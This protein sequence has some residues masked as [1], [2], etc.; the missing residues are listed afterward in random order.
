MH[1]LLA[2]YRAAHASELDA[3]DAEAERLA[4]RLDQGRLAA[5]RTWPFPLHEPERLRELRDE[6]DRRFGPSGATP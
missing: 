3:L 4:A 2:E 5:D 1:E 6:I